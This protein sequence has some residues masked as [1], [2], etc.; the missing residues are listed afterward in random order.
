[1]AGVAVLVPIKA[2]GNAKVRLAASLTLEERSALAREMARHV[3][4]AAGAPVTVVCDDQEVASWAAGEGAAVLLMPGRGLNGAVTAG[5]THLASIGFARVVVA[6][7]DLPLAHD[8]ASLASFDGI[9]LVP[10]RHDDGTNVICVPA[11]CG[12]EFAYGPASFAKHQANAM[13]L[14]VPL[15]IL[16]EPLLAWDVD[17]PADLAYRTGAGRPA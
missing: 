9:T 11:E 10:D 6:H 5:V 15:R 2:F 12:F 3:I 7:A 1:V 8:L 13:T 14:E 17:V 16:R 4:G